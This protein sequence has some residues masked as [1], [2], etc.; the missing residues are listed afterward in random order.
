MFKRKPSEY[1][2]ERQLFEYYTTYRGARIPYSQ[3]KYLLK[4][5]FTRNQITNICRRARRR[6]KIFHEEQDATT[7]EEIYLKSIGDHIGKWMEDNP[8]IIS[9]FIALLPKLGSKHHKKAIKNLSKLIPPAG[10]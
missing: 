5:G 9:Q 3:T 4:K 6:A 1:E 7:R 2:I 10:I 8:E